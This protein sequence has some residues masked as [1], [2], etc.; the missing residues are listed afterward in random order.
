MGDAMK[1]LE[2]RTLDSKREKDILAALDEMK[3]MKSRHAT[4]IVDAM[5]DVLRD[6]T[7]EKERK[8]EEEEEALIK[9]LFKGEREKF[10]KLIRDED[11]EDEDEDDEDIDVV[12]HKS[13]ESSINFLKRKLPEEISSNPTDVFAKSIASDGKDK[14]VR[15]GDSSKENYFQIIIS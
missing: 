13:G 7:E 8:K 14:A 12:K 11:I 6:S 9:Y 2:N 1:S 3:S 4:V 5:L 10:I 15:K